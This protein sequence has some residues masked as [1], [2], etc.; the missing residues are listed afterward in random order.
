M[1]NEIYL[2]TEEK[3]NMIIRMLGSTIESLDKINS[4]NDE[5]IELLSC[6]DCDCEEEDS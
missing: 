1:G 4:T 5:L 3:L 6:D 2:A